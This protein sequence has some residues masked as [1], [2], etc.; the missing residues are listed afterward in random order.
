M[1]PR[2][3]ADALIEEFGRQAL[4]IAREKAIET[5]MPADWKV[6]RCIETHFNVSQ[7]KDT[8]TRYLEH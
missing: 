7:Q 4:S 5:Q 8:A 6:L 1:T 2:A 3:K